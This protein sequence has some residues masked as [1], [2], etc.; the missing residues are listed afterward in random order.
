MTKEAMSAGL[1]L[2]RGSEVLLVHPGGPFWAN[3]DEGAWSIPKGQLEGDEEPLA[4]AIR[5]TCEE[6]GV[7]APAGPFVPV[8]EIR[9]KSGKRVLAWACLADVDVA[10][11]KSNE[12]VIEWPPRS[13]KLM[14]IPEVDR[15]AWVT[16]ER[17]RQLVNPAQIPL[18][19]RALAEEMLARLGAARLP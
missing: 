16:R 7:A 9:L 11:V 14:R 2:V 8:G 4:A 13:G 6:L 1:V 15:A 18:I 3:K 10:Q 19:E 17:A 12:I 5:E